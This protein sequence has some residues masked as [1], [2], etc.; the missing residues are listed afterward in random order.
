MIS[1]GSLFSR[2]AAP[3]LGLDISSSSVKLVE[4]GRDKAGNYV[5]ER[6]WLTDVRRQLIGTL[7]RGYRQRV[8]LA[9]ALLADEPRLRD[10][11]PCLLHLDRID[12]AR[13]ARAG[14]LVTKK[15]GSRGGAHSQKPIGSSDRYEVS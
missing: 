1:L 13:P 4:L 5:L 15:S 7:S 9:D 10:V 6:C 2:Q 3:L 12:H 11:R 14:I 8:G